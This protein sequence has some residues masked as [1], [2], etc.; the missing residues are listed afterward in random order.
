MLVFTA[1]AFGKLSSCM[2]SNVDT[3][4]ESKLEPRAASGLYCRSEAVILGGSGFQN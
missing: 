3:R 1:E 2:T 4:G